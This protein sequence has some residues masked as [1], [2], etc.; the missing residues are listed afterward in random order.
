MYSKAIPSVNK[1]NPRYPVKKNN[2]DIPSPT[3]PISAR[4]LPSSFSPPQLSGEET[5]NLTLHDLKEDPLRQT[6]V[7]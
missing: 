7:R 4:N 3:T 1:A 5:K 6:P 2:V